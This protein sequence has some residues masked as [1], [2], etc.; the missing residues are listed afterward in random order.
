MHDSLT[1]DSKSDAIKYSAVWSSTASFLRCSVV[2]L[3]LVLSASIHAVHVSPSGAGE[4]L[5]VP[6]YTT[7]GEFDTLLEVSNTRES[8]ENAVALKVNFVSEEGAV[9]TTLNVYLRASGTW[10]LALTADTEG[11][12]FGSIATGCTLA[13][14]ADGNMSAVENFTLEG[15]PNGY[16]EIVEM[17]RLT[18]S[19]LRS[20][21]S[22]QDCAAF[23]DYWDDVIG[24]ELDPDDVLGPP[25]GATRASASLINVGRAT[26]YSVAATPL[27]NFRTREWHSPPTEIEPDLSSAYNHPV[28][29]T[30]LNCFATPCIADEWESAIDAVS[31]ALMVRRMTGSYVISE[32]IEAR[33]EWVLT[34]PML[35]Y[36]GD[37]PVDEF[38]NVALILYFDRHG[39]SLANLQ[40]PTSP[41]PWGE[42][43]HNDF[44][45]IE[46]PVLGLPIGPRDGDPSQARILDLSPGMG[47]SRFDSGSV[48][49]GLGGTGTPLESLA[50]RKYRGQPVIGVNLQEFNNQYIAGDGSGSRIASYGNAYGPSYDMEVTD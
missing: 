24:S 3:A 27:A 31:A 17:G 18:D 46:K 10:A 8:G 44:A 23:A 34:A 47:Q 29:T 15:A 14:D 21:L 49:V 28:T 19:G 38:D 26:L 5:I 2:I 6:I 50:G 11:R 25:L 32:Q 41:P 30:S 43:S 33:T 45:S 42:F 22:D 37:E 1:I 4:A 9:E 20:A 35:R 7:A 12:A 39:D 13:A 48:R 16:I 36:R 40:V